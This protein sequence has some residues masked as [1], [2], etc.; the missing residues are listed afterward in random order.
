[1]ARYGNSLCS[2]AAARFGS[3]HV[4]LS[5]SPIP[6]CTLQ[7]PSKAI[8]VK[9]YFVVTTFSRAGIN[10]NLFCLTLVV[11]ARIGRVARARVPIAVI[12]VVIMQFKK[13]NLRSGWLGGFGRLSKPDIHETDGNTRKETSKFGPEPFGKTRY[14]NQV[15]AIY[16]N[17]FI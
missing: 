10:V 6:I 12:R 16:R 1:M 3:R 13:C 4:L 14:S 17:M 8:T 15:R 2:A 9:T 5:T 7:K 11:A